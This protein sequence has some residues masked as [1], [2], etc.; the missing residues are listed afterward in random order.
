AVVVIAVDGLPLKETLTALSRHVFAPAQVLV[1]GGEETAASGDVTDTYDPPPRVVPSPEAVLSGLDQT[2]SFVWWIHGDTRPRPDALQALIRETIRNDAGVGGSKILIDGTGDELESVGG[3]TDVFGELYSGLDAGELDQEQY[4]VV[5]EVGFVSPVS[6]LVRRDLL[7]GLGGLDRSLPVQAAGVDLSQRARVAG[8]KV[9]VV[10]SSEVFHR[11]HCA[12]Q[13]PGWREQAGRHKAMLVAYRPLSLIWV[14]HIGI[15]AGLADG[16]AQLGL[17]RLR[18]LLA[19]IAGWIWT[20]GQLPSIVAARRRLARIRRVGD[21][22]LFRFQVRG[23]VQLRNTLSELSQRFGRALAEEEV[24]ELAERARHAWRRPSFVAGAV[25]ALLALVATR[26]IW[27]IG[28]PQ[29]GFGLNPVGTSGFAASYGGGWD[30]AGL[31]GP[32]P[33]APVTALG[34]LA[35][36]LLGNRPRLAGALLTLL[37]VASGLIGMARLARRAGAGAAGG[38]IAGW[39]FVA[40]AAASAI[41]ATGAWPALLAAGAL[42]WALDAVFAPSVGDWRR[43]LG[44]YARG[45]LAGG[46]VAV[47]YP[48]MLVIVPIASLVWAAASRRPG[49][50]ASGWVVTA[51]GAGLIAPFVIAGD[52]LPML[53]T[54][55]QPSLEPGWIWAAPLGVGAVV[56]ALLTNRTHLP[57]AWFGGILG[58]GGWLVASLPSLW[59]G[60]VLVGLM[61]AS[62]G[63][64][65]LG[66]VLSEVDRRPAWRR[67]AG[68]AAAALLAV[69]TAGAIAKGSIGLPPDQWSGTLDFVNSL[70]GD[71]GPGRVLLI[72]P[73]PSLPGSSRFV[74]GISYRLIDNGAPSL[75]QAYLPRPGATDLT[76]Q[77]AIADHLMTGVDLRPGQALSQF[78]IEWLVILPDSGLP[79]DALERQVDLISRPLNPELMVY[80]NLVKGGIAV[81][82]RGANW[83]PEGGEYVGSPGPGRVRLAINPHPGWNPEGSVMDGW[84]QSVSAEMGRAYFD[85][86]S[87]IRWS[88][89]FALTLMTTLIATAYWGRSGRPASPKPGR[90]KPTSDQATS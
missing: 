6:L 20:A 41:F 84:V 28:L 55:T 13:S 12:D 8:A 75:E 81:T 66:A 22:E 19:T 65:L 73:A 48:P 23:A 49:A 32:L 24:D 70:A 83:I 80:E 33:A 71:E 68:L 51:L 36:L 4:D 34:E 1:V 25:S 35:N 82:D 17:G 31:G 42:P 47:A 27:F 7:K 88:G 56:A 85:P 16:I 14:I 79:A 29:A 72:G 59:P 2:V 74:N 58:V 46:L 44:R 18:P 10:P 60:S 76:L 77:Q 89:W 52:L 90:P 38:L 54:G 5:R 50:I 86:D 57:G 15:L 11:R 9:I 21:V 40:G 67:V 45:G 62:L 53:S 78:G 69:P 43:R 61:A 64:A 87:L 63:T 3:A 26:R 39:V 30:P 37:A